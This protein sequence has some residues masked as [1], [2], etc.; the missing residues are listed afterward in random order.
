MYWPHFA[1]PWSRGT[2]KRATSRRVSSVNEVVKTDIK[3]TWLLINEAFDGIL[4]LHKVDR[5]EDLLNF[6]S[7][8]FSLCEQLCACMKENVFMSKISYLATIDAIRK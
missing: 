8:L 2:L 6:I 7:V 3:K 4:I 1:H 5:S